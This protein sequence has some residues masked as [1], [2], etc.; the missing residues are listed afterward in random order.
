MKYIVMRYNHR[1]DI[2]R[3]RSIS[4]SAVEVDLFF[5]WQEKKRSNRIL[6]QYKKREKNMIKLD[7]KKSIPEFDE[8][9]PMFTIWNVV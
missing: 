1:Y 4:L 3:Q 9:L 8:P 5:D 2:V 7:E 6:D